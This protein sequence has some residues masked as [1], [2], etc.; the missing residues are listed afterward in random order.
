[1]FVGDD[2]VAMFVKIKD[3]K[4]IMATSKIHS[5]HTNN[6][7]YTSVGDSKLKH[8]LIE[9]TDLQGTCMVFCEFPQLQQ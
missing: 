2:G 1:M 6:A 7:L 5:R 9:I 4:R 8:I 3:R